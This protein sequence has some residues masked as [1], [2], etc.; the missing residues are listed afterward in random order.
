MHSIIVDGIEFRFFDHLFAV[1]RD[2]KVLRKLAPYSPPKRPDGYLSCGR[3]RLLHR[4]VASCWLEKPVNASL[5][6]HKNRNKADNRATNLEW[7]TPKEHNGERHIDTVGRHV[8]SDETRALMRAQHLGKKTPE[9][10]KQKQREASLRLGCTPPPR[11]LGFKCSKESVA[12]MQRNNPMNV[13]CE[14]DGVLYPSFAEASRAMGVKLH[15]IRKR[16]LSKNFPGY[17]IRVK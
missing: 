7:L 15:T 17:R 11:P 16:C 13:A 9:A 6:H 4:V 5:V 2:G 12:L 1:S 14:I 8:V 3:H 10:T